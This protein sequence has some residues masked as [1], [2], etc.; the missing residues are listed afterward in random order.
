MIRAG[1]LRKRFDVYALA[2]AVDAFGGEAKVYAAA[3][4]ITLWGEFEV[5]TGHEVDNAGQVQ[6]VK[7]T[8]VRC[9]YWSGLV[10]SMRLSL[11][12]SGRLFNI[13]DIENVCERGREMLVTVKEIA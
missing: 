5:K 13:G 11:R 2:A 8:R 9:R 6:E 12:P 4:A 10:S 7:T 1:K 3:P